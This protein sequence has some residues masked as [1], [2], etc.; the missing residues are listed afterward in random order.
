MGRAAHR[1]RSRASPARR[2]SCAAGR[3]GPVAL[4][5]ALD[6]SHLS[7]DDAIAALRSY[8]R[9]FREALTSVDPDELPDEAV[10][11]ADHVARSLALL[12]EALRQVLV[13]DNPTLMPAVTD[14]GARDWAHSSGSSVDDTL[15]FLAMEANA[16][17][18]AAAGAPADAWVRVGTIAGSG[19]STSALEVLRE[20]VRTGSE[21]L[22]AAEGALPAR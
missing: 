14:D 1:A 20:A 12:G 7:P 8:P 4:V 21:H 10:D 3:S 16:I 5:S 19:P 22:R 6:L 9:R 15:A 11:H 17:A 18:D 13:Q 2:R